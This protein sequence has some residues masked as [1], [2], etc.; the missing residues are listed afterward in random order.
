MTANDKRPAIPTV[1]RFLDRALVIVAIALMLFGAFY[2]IFDV[3]PGREGQIMAVITAVTAF[4]GGLVT[5]R[6]SLLAFSL[7]WAA[8][9][10]SAA[11]GTIGF[12]SIG[13]VYLI[14]AVLLLLAIFATPNRSGIELRYDMRYI[15]AFVI[16]YLSM[17]F[18]YV[19]LGSSR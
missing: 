1:H 19:V 8:F 13:F 10:M 9:G 11:F 14:A 7:L 12:F 2:P 5:P 17:F 18:F 4:I 3:L 6:G 16:G 15:A